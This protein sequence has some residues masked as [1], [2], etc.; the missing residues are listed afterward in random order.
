MNA[1]VI[2]LTWPVPFTHDGFEVDHYTVTSEKQNTGDIN[3]V[4]VDDNEYVLYKMGGIAEQCEEIICTVT[5]SNSIG[6]SSGMQISTGFPTGNLCTRL[7][8]YAWIAT[9]VHQ[10]F[11]ACVALCGWIK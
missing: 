2:Q 6:E 5:A 8:H 4:D 11:Y 1:T 9:F 10:C 3:A 7:F